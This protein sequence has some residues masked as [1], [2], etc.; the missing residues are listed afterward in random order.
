MKADVKGL[1]LDVTVGIVLYNALLAVIALVIY[2]KSTVF[3]GLAV[4]MVVALLM[5]I[6]MTLTFQQAAEEA[7]EGAAKRRTTIGVIVRS[8][9]Y[10]G[11]LIV[12]LW[13]VPQI[14]IIAVAL[15]AMGLKAAAYA[16]PFIHKVM[17]REAVQKGE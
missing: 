10:I 1:I 16:Q 14:N 4:G 17:V 15:G 12:I 2:P 7:D 9:I 3:L 8:T 13:K 11:L 5:F 6:H